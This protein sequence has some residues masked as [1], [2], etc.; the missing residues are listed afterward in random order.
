MFFFVTSDPQTCG[1][2]TAYFNGTFRN[3]FNPNVERKVQFQ[4]K[5]NATDKT[6]YGEIDKWYEQVSPSKDF[7]WDTYLDSMFS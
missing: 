6:V 5:I 2:F 3:K 7:R 4:L 1:T